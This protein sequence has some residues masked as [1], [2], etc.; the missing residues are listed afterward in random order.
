MKVVGIGR[1]LSLLAVGALS[2]PAAV[3]LRFNELPFQP[4]NG[5]TYLG[6]T[7]GF[8]ISGV[9]SHDANYNSFGPGTITFVQDPSL[10]GNTAGVLRLDFAGNTSVLGFGVALATTATLTP[11]FT[12]QLFD[13]SLNSLGTFPVN[14]SV[15][16]SFTE[17]HFLYN[18]A[19]PVRRAVITFSALATRFALDNLDFNI[20]NACGHEIVHQHGFHEHHGAHGHTVVS[21]CPPH[22]PGHSAGL[23]PAP[24]ESSLSELSVA[25]PRPALIAVLNEDG[26]FNG[27]SAVTRIPG[28]TI[29]DAR[30][31]E[32]IQ[33]LGSATGL[34]LSHDGPTSSWGGSGYSVTRFA[35]DVRVGGAAARVLFSGLAPEMV[36]VWQVNVQIPDEA[37]AG[38]V[39]LSISYEGSEI[40]P[41][42]VIIK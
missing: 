41:L 18:G 35:P 32:V 20:V 36:G 2:A 38:R 10:E 16:I 24:E 12:V 29:R 1:I 15:L 34:W 33:L 5:L 19:T 28:A 9:P 7:F 22:A 40:A 17:G 42:E 3:T 8:T 13:A 4:V 30:R 26:T 11:G 37:P 21:G 6:V 23:S 14:T 39:P 27:D 31:G 25:T